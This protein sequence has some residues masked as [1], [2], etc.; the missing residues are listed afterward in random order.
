MKPFVVHCRSK[1]ELRSKFKSQDMNG[2]GKLSKN[3]IKKVFK[4]LGSS[5]GFYRANRAMHRADSD[6]NGYVD[7]NDDK[8]LEGL[9]QY[10]YQRGYKV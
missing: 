3:E 5:S 1:E 9:V 2:D 6:H 8:E 10:A 7:I 4:D